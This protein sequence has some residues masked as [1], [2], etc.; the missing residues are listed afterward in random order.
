MRSARLF[1]THAVHDYEQREASAVDGG[2]NRLISQSSLM[3]SVIDRNLSKSM[4]NVPMDIHKMM[5]LRSHSGSS[6][7]SWPI[8]CN[9][10][11]FC[12]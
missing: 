3:S 4:G 8:K 7:T 5:M 2:K 9:K 6:E 1:T 11:T 10:F 12:C